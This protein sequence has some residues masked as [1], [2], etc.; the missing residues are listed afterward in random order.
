V[1]SL[2]TQVLLTACDVD[3]PGPTPFPPVNLVDISVATATDGGVPSSYAALDELG[4]TI[5][6]VA[7]TSFRVRFDRLLLPTETFRQSMCLAPGVAPVTALKS[8]ANGVFLEPSYDPVRRQITY[9]QPAVSAG[10]APGSH[11]TI[12]VFPPPVDGTTNGIAAFDGAPLERAQSRT[13]ITRA[14]EPLGTV[15]DV[16]PTVDFC[17]DLYPNL[18]RDTCAASGCHTANAKEDHGLILGPAEGL[19]FSSPAAVLATAVSHVAHGAQTGEHAAAGESSPSLFGRAMPILDPT[20]P[21][22]SYALY[23]LLANVNNGAPGSTPDLEQKRL[24]DLDRLRAVVV[25]GIP[26]PPSDGRGKELDQARLEQL[27]DWI[28]QGA[29]TSCP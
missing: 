4:T 21:G 10:L 2:A 23:K 8:C 16:P 13:F 20:R 6:V 3:H 17:G 15:V 5:D 29:P 24:A 28:A 11:Y 14:V 1:A 27:S 25:V 19:D 18:L 26:M 12:S 7:K 22:N 9:R